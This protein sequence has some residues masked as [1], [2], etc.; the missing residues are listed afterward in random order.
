MPTLTR[1]KKRLLDGYRFPG[2]RPLPEVVGVFGDPHARVV[3]LVRRSKKPL[4]ASAVEC[5]RVG[6]IAPVGARAIWRAG[7]IASIW[8]SR[9]GGLRSAVAA[10]RMARRRRLWASALCRPSRGVRV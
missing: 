10:R 3:R 2:F 8:S 6:M 5:A 9:W 4:V 1:R 7:L